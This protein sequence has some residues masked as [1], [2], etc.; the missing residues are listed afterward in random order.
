MEAQAVQGEKMQE[1]EA[2]PKPKKSTKAS[3][4]WLSSADV[5][6]RYGSISEATLAR[7]VARSQ[8]PEPVSFGGRLR[9]WD[10][11]EL[12]EFDAKRKAARDAAKEV[13]RSKRRER[14]DRDTKKARG[15][16]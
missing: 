6:E 14:E 15:E 12:D 3:V 7:W 4:R 10:E 16:A 8:F 13:Q 9:L 11:R 1:P 2:A 5:I